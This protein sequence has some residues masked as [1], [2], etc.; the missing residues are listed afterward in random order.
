MS[1]AE[2]VANIF[3]KAKEF[4]IDLAAQLRQVR[5][6]NTQLNELL[7]SHEVTIDSL[8]RSQELD[9]KMIADLQERNR[10]LERLNA[11]LFSRGDLII[12]I[13]KRDGG[14]LFANSEVH[15][16]N[17]INPRRAEDDMTEPFKRLEAMMEDLKPKS[18]HAGGYIKQHE[19]QVSETADRSG[20]AEAAS[21]SSEAAKS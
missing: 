8:R 1:S 18:E 10:K 13:I 15:P 9:G 2:T 20:L 7:S 21:A 5:A 6:D 3:D 4:T 11:V 12:D 19:K 17:I 14:D 16:E